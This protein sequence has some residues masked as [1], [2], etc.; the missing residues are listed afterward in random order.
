MRL[1]GHILWKDARRLW[2]AV[3]LSTVLVVM[4]A[5]TD[6]WRAGRIPSATEGWLNLLL[7]LIWACVAAVAVQ[8]EPLAGDRSWWLTRPYP[9][10]SLLAAKLIFVIVAIHLPAF[11][12]D[13]YILRAHG[14]SAASCLGM[15]LQKQLFL[16]GVVTLP[17]MALATLVRRFASFLL[18]SVAIASGIV[19][20]N[21]GFGPLPNYW[22]EPAG[23]RQFLAGAAFVLAAIAIVAIQYTR[24]NLAISRAVA[25]CAGV[26]SCAIGVALPARLAFAMT[27]P[28]SARIRLRIPAGSPPTVY[29]PRN[30]HTLLIPITLE[31]AGPGRL[32]GIQLRISNTEGFQVQSGNPSPYQPD[33]KIEMLAYLIGLHNGESD[34]LSVR[35]AGPAWDRMK[36]GPVSITGWAAID[37]YR[38]G[39]ASNIPISGTHQIPGI[40]RC[41]ATPVGD[42]FT[43]DMLKVLCE[44]P[45]RAPAAQLVLRS[46]GREWKAR[47]NSSRPAPALS[48]QTWLSPL[49]R[50]E[51]FFHL[52]LEPLDAPGA[53]WQIPVQAISNAQ[54]V[55]TPEIP[56]GRVVAEIDLPGVDLKR[57]VAPR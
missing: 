56:A 30:R 15:L 2:P 10:R 28:G 21:G 8:E 17:A 4:L 18:V 46:G 45:G 44:S 48:R 43:Q 57:W 29:S 47:L 39:P 27:S 16:L 9:W 49:Q 25:I 42:P 55:I 23:A 1:T 7:P 41:G 31:G 37:Q 34:W 38:L 51:E 12:A 14:L 20:L 13:I 11:L 36:D 52:T 26:L 53:Q 22:P 5:N 40:G 3:A 54:L 35:I 32:S 6:R 50:G 24:R 33:D 19:V